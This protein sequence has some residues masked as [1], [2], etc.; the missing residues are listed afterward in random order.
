MADDT[1]LDSKSLVEVVGRPL[2]EVDDRL[3][4]SLAFVAILLLGIV[5]VSTGP[6][7]SLA[8]FYLVPV[9]AVAWRCGRRSALIIALFAGVAWLGAD[10][11]FQ[12][13]GTWVQIWNATVRTSVFIFFGVV[14][15][16]LRSAINHE[17]D[18]ARI[19]MVT[20]VA[21]RRC[22]Y[23]LATLEI[24]RARRFNRPLTLVYLD[25]DRFKSVNDRFGHAAGDRVLR[26]VADVL[27]QSTRAIDTVARMG[28]DEFALLLP[29]TNEAGAKVVVHNVRE[30]LRAR[31]GPAE[32]SVTL[33]MGVRT[34]HPPPAVV[35]DMITG[36]DELMYDVKKSGKDGVRYLAD[37][38]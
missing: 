30:R 29:E 19:D 4:L 10:A 27:R 32:P 9:G 20:G 14:V 2:D 25:C 37:V 15:A 18:L 21:N 23:E 33:S 28:G 3:V 12:T 11:Y 36:A 31:F 8:I 38:A 1:E 5:D 34:Y 35:D 16:E 17:R 7:I 6:D 24:S 22:F 13:T 26:T